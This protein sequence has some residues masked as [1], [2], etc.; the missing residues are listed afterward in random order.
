M[1][2]AIIPS[3]LYQQ[4]ADDSDLQAFVNAYNTIAQEYLNTFINIDLP[5]YTSSMITGQ[6]LDWVGNGL[7][8]FPRPTLSAPLPF[9]S[10]GSYDTEPYDTVPYSYDDKGG[11]INYYTVTD[12]Y[13]KR[14]LTWNFYKGDG[15]QYTTTWLKKRI[16]RFLNGVNGAP[17]QID[18]TYNISVTYSGEYTIDINIPDTTISPIFKAGIQEGALYVP[19]QYTYNVTY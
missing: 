10:G 17:L 19:F 14:M 16:E 1:K 12:D 5:I 15:F 18:N 4:Y 9:S 7:Y 6:L 13:Y 3:Y 11:T 8:G 2:T